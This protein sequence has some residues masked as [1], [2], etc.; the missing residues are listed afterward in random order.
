[1]KTRK[2]KAIIKT[3]EKKGF[4]YYPENDHHRFYYLTIDGKK[5][6]IYT[7]FSHGKSEYN[8]NLMGM[9]KKQLKFIDSKKAEMFFDCPLTKE[10][11]LE[12]LKEIGVL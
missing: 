7:Y 9:L 4:E 10:L 5:T 1:M 3:L 12:M 6:S 8:S 11:Y 2:T